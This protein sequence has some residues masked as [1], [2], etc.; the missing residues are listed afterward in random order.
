MM[1]GP[2]MVLGVLLMLAACQGSLPDPK[3]SR[4][5]ET[6]PARALHWRAA[7]SCRGDEGCP[8]DGKDF[9]S[10]SLSGGGMKATIFS[11]ESMFYLD[12]VGLLPHVGMLSSV[13]GGSFAAAYYALSVD[14]TDAPNVPP[15]RQPPWKYEPAMATVSQ[16][17]EPMVWKGLGNALLP[18]RPNSVPVTEFADFI[19][20]T[21][22][23]D[24][25][26]GG[27]GFNFG[28]LNPRRPVLVLNSTLVSNF[29]SLTELSENKHMLRRRTADEQLHFA[30][31]QYYFS[32]IKSDLTTFPLSYGVASSAAFPALIGYGVLTNYS[33]CDQ[34]DLAAAADGLNPPAPPGSAEAERQRASCLKKPQTWLTLTDGGAND[35]QG[36]IEVFETLAELA[37]SEQRSDLSQHVPCPALERGMA[38]NT[39]R[40]DCFRDSDR[41]LALVVNTSVT[42]ATGTNSSAGVL[43]NLPLTL[44]NFLY[45]SVQR[46]G[47]ATDAYSASGYNLR[48][49]LYR[50]DIDEASV[51]LQRADV[52]ITPLEIGLVTLDDYSTGGTIPTFIAD[53][54]VCDLNALQLTGAHRGPAYVAPR[55]CLWT[56]RADRLARG[57]PIRSPRYRPWPTPRWRS[58]KSA[59][60]CSW[61]K[62]TPNACSRKPRWWMGTFWRL[63]TWGK[64]TPCA[65]AMPHAGR[66]PCAWRR[67]ARTWPSPLPRKGS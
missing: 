45:G 49:R 5:S 52:L 61:E 46:I 2:F 65:C 11:A 33:F 1:R 44:V 30:F 51:N 34:A 60:R 4:G 54:A 64:K 16:G 18:G 15:R 32:R 19:D 14:G 20:R 8:E 55:R 53:A 38:V 6:E 57:P 26:S 10:L 17:F 39:V 62:C 50:A 7:P 24:G 66:P 23:Q 67:F 25:K 21:Y 36:L 43:K 37:G 35:N 63:P 3:N 9:I 47:Q 31:T 29:R 40:P 59:R 12:A 48:N 28:D 13:S 58:R 56:A 27:T 41:A 42:E 22:F